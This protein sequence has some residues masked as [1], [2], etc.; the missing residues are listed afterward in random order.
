MTL[1]VGSPIEGIEKNTPEAARITDQKTNRLLIANQPGTKF[2]SDL[3]K[4]LHIG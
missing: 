2:R 4:S 3:P 1:G